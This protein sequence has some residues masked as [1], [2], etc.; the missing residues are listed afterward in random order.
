VRLR[1]RRE[2]LPELCES[3]AYDHV[4][5]R[6]YADRND[7]KLVRLPPRPPRDHGVLAN[8]ELLRRAFLD[9]LELRRPDSSQDD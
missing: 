9:R 7:V 1:R 6:T 8:G 3:E 5:D 2:R 4:Y